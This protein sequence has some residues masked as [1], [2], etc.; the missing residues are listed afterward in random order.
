[1]VVNRKKLSEYCTPE[2][3]GYMSNFIDVKRIEGGVSEDILREYQGKTRIAVYE[4]QDNSCISARL[5]PYY[6]QTGTPFY[7]FITVGRIS[8]EKNYTCLISAFAKLNKEY[9]NSCLYILGDG[10]LKKQLLQMVKQYRLTN[11]VFLPGNVENPFAVMKY[12][13]CFILPSLHEGQPMVINE[14]RVL[15]LPI[16]VSNF[17][18]VNSVL[19]EDGQLV[20]GMSVEDIYKGM[21]TFIEG[22]VPAHYNFNADSYNL[23]VYKEFLKVLTD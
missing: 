8:V 11:N 5:I 20:I 21:K 16:I 23:N 10:P 22:K 4:N 1:M 15:K 17:S 14:A 7:R 19:V 6:P 18:S 12:C 13:D 9:P 2:K 3:F